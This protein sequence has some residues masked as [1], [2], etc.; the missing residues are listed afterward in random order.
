[1]SADPSDVDAYIAAAPVPAQDTLRDLRT[2]VLGLLGEADERISYRI[3]VFVVGTQVVGM[4]LSATHVSLYSMSPGLIASLE[5]SLS[6]R[7]VKV[8][9]AT[10][11]VRHGERFPPEVV[12]AV[13]RGRMRELGLTGEGASP[14]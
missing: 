14:G 8:A 10:V 9:G 2:Q 7:G 12:Q 5:P 4:G 11:A 1:M 6:G 13:V 3:P